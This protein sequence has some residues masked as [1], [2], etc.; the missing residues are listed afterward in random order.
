MSKGQAAL[1]RLTEEQ[2]AE[3]L[4]GLRW[5]TGAACTH[6]GSV[7]VY[8]LQGPAYRLTL[9]HCRDCRKQ[10]SV[11]TGTVMERSRVKMWQWVYVFA[12]MAASKKGISSHQIHRELGVQ[13]KT[14]WFMAQRARYVMKHPDG[15]PKLTGTLEMDET[16]VGGKPRNPGEVVPKTPVV[17]LLERNGRA[18]GAVT[19]DVTAK[20]LREHAL[21]NADVSARLMT[22]ENS[23]Y[24]ALGKKFKGGHQTVNHS[25][26]EYARGDVFSN[27]AES[28]F[29]LLKRGVYGVFHHVSPEHLHFYVAEF[30][31]GWNTRDMNDTDRTFEALRLVEGKRLYYRKPK[32][33]I[34]GGQQFFGPTEG[35]SKAR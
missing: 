4:E 29:A 9:R 21:K 31:F 28:Y 17:V 34:Q 35:A 32:G 8:R 15:A 14:A 27:T 22:D 5:P 3:L 24:K 23:S 30:D 1:K 13:Y 10:F 19:C 33:P 2:A 16:Y 12:A 18:R 11:T 20:N 6:C 26:K 25:N 7:D